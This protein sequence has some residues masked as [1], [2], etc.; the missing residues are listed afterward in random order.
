MDSRSGKAVVRVTAAPVIE[1]AFSFYVAEKSALRIGS[2]QQPWLQGLQRERP[3]LIERISTFWAAGGYYEWAELIILAQRSGTL[4][5]EPEEFLARLEETAAK[6]YQVP[7]LPSEADTVRPI[8]QERLDRLAASAEFRASYSSLVREFWEELKPHWLG[9]AAALAGEMV[10]SYQQRLARAEDIRETLPRN[11]FARR[12]AHAVVV[13]RALEAGEAVI[14]PLAL[15]GAGIAFF[16]LPGLVLMAVGPEAEK[17][18]DKRREAAEKAAARFK[19]L[20]D[21][22]RLSILTSFCS[23]PYSISELADFFDLSQP[24]V[25]VH[26]KMLR[27]AGLLEA[28]K[29]RGQT[30]YRSSREKVSELLDSA[31]AEIFTA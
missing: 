22:T 18:Q 10:A 21:P 13:A 20:S 14:V 1:L 31:L 3:D 27:E 12:A 5:A 11:H 26:V 6:R 29:V 9:G 7:Q 23:S 28:T 30:L 8:L 25:S 17:H 16:A 15:S 24:T 19:L 2:F 4:L